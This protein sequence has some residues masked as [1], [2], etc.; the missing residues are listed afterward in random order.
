M[1]RK[2]PLP[3]GVKLNPVDPE[4]FEVIADSIIKIADTFD[5]IK[6]GPL[7]M[8]TIILL[9]SSV[10]G[11]NRTEVELVLNAAANLKKHYIK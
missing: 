7:Q 4:P 5:R 11:V 9:I 1:V 10:S 3:K 6:N 8:K 2:S